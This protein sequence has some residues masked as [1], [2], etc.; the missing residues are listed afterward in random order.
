MWVGVYS[1]DYMQLKTNP[2]F[3]SDPVN[4]DVSQQTSRMYKDRGY[5]IQT[6]CKWNQWKLIN[7][8]KNGI[9]ISLHESCVNKVKRFYN[10]IV[11]DI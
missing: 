4:S 7:F 5:H 2:T 6:T 11:G 10:S 8:L 3:P 1:N 9:N